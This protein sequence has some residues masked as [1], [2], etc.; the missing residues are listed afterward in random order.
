MKTKRFEIHWR[1]YDN[2]ETCGPD[3]AFE[4][5]ETTSKK[6]AEKYGKA[7]AAP[8]HKWFFMGVRLINSATAG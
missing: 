4:E 1:H 5:V 6:K 8:K 2:G 3:D 7:V